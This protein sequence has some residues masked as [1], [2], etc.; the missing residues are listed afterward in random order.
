MKNIKNYSPYH[1]TNRKMSNITAMART[2]AGYDP[3]ALPDTF[4]VFNYANEDIR[5]FL[6][7]HWHNFKA[8]HPMWYMFLGMMYFCIGTFLLI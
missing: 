3:M 4:T 2:V 7:P 8:I 5:A 6:H 1:F